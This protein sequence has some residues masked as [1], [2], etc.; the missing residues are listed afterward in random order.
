MSQRIE[1]EI[2][3]RASVFAQIAADGKVVVEDV[4]IDLVDG[5]LT[6]CFVEVIDAPA[7]EPDLLAEADERILALEYENL[8]LQERLT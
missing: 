8:L 4:T 2:E 1:Y 3:N 7:A 5:R 6:N